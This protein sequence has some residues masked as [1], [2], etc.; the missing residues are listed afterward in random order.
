LAKIKIILLCAIAFY[1][2]E[3]QGASGQDDVSPELARKAAAYLINKYHPEEYELGYDVRVSEPRIY[4]DYTGKRK[5]YAVYAYFGPGDMPSWDTIEKERESFFK[6]ANTFRSF[7]IPADK[8]E[9]F[10]TIGK[11]TIP[12]TLISHKRAEERLRRTEPSSS[13]EYRR[14]II[15]VDHIYFVFLKGSEEV[16]VNPGGRIIEPE[17]LPYHDPYPHHY[18]IWNEIEEYLQSG[19]I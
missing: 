8:K 19:D 6:K 11:G 13:W 17:D 9:F 14:T 18:R 12:I 4:Y 10:Y 15:A 16:I 1:V 5:Y 2:T 3:A 7:I